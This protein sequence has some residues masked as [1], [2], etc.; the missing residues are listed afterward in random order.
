MINN[1]F[2]CIFV[3]I[4]KTAGSSIEV[5]FDIKIA[6][7]NCSKEQ[8]VIKVPNTNVFRIV[9]PILVS[10]GISRIICPE[11]LISL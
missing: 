10:R 1:E 3:H 2:K 7:I 5:F 9:A 8:K 4:P 11:K 6:K